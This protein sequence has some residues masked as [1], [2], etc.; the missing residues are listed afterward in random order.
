[1]FRDP[2][3]LFTGTQYG[4]NCKIYLDEIN[5]EDMDDDEY[6]ESPNRKAIQATWTHGTAC[7]LHSEAHKGRGLNT[8]SQQLP[9]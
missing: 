4:D 2:D 9:L 8:P 3:G 6:H 1:M 7:A 5:R